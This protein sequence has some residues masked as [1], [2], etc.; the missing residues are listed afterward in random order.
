M[1]VVFMKLYGF[2]QKI[3]TPIKEIVIQSNKKFE[4]TING[5][6]EV[7]PFPLYS[8]EHAVVSEEPKYTKYANTCAIL[9]MSNGKKTYLGHFAPENHYADFKNKLERNVKKMQDETGQLSAVV[10]GG[11]NY[12]VAGYNDAKASFEQLAEIGEVLDKAG[13]SITMLAGKRQPLFKDNMAVTPER[14]ILSQSSN[15]V[16]FDPVPDFKNCKTKQDFENLGY[17][18]YGISELDDVHNIYFEG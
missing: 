3:Y 2:N 15:R 1:K 16:G 6:R 17:K 7:S 18:H 5:F 12:S 11:Y 14:F 4:E 10:T 13:A 8:I 9:G